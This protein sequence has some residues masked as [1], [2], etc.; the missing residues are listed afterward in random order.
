MSESDET[1]SE[2]SDDEGMR[3]L[4]HLEPAEVTRL[5][6]LTPKP[7]RLIHGSSLTLIAALDPWMTSEGRDADLES[8]VG[9]A[10]LLSASALGK[11]E[12]KAKRSLMHR[13]FT[14][15]SFVMG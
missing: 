13:Y 8:A 2:T 15:C 7:S 9:H 6:G 12:G 5:L 1:E 4:A 11:Q 10:V 14:F 3:L